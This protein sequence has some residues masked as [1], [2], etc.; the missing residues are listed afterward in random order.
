MTWRILG[1]DDDNHGVAFR[2]EDGTFFSNYRDLSDFLCE[3]H[4]T[5]YEIKVF[6]IIGD[7]SSDL[8]EMGDEKVEGIFDHLSGIY[9]EPEDL[10]FDK[11]FN[12][13]WNSA[14]NI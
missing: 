9:G 12:L 14:D 3:P 5:K 6:G 8:Q 4:D 7:L 1:L 2:C 10:D 11:C 13:L